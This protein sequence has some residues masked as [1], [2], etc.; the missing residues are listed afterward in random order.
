MLTAEKVTVNFGG[1][2]AL[3]DVSME[4]GDGEVVGLVGPNGAGK[5]T[6]F[7][8]ISGLVS[9][10]T[11][12]ILVD[13]RDLS[14]APAYQRPRAGIG[15]AFQVPQPLPGLT[16]RENLTVAQHFGAGKRDARRLEEILETVGL[17]K[18]A[19]ADAVADLSLSE[20]KM[21]EVAKALSTAPRLLLLDEV[22]AGLPSVMKQRFVGVLQRIRTAFAVTLIMIEHDIETIQSFCERAVVLDYG[23]IVAD[24]TPAAVFAHPDV[25][26][27][28]TGA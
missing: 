9:P 17:R 12:R 16:V 10:S 1:L 8:V 2:F 5:T 13:G 4:I 20:Q 3:R 19:D 25:M 18:K 23:Q 24:G 21:L 6:L 7:N 28:Y 26:R 27:S 22:L 14:R 11:G 15:R